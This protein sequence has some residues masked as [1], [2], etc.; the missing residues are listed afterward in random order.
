M[1]P[2]LQCTGYTARPA[3]HGEAC[4]AFRQAQLGTSAAPCST[5]AAWRCANC[6]LRLGAKGVAGS[7][8]ARHY[9]RGGPRG[10]TGQTRDHGPG[11]I[12]SLDWVGGPQHGFDAYTWRHR[13]G[14]VGQYTFKTRWE[15]CVPRVYGEAHARLRTYRA[16]CCVASLLTW[17]QGVGKSPFKKRANLGGT[18]HGARGRWP[19]A[20]PEG[21]WPPQRHE[22]SCVCRGLSREGEGRCNSRRISCK[23]ICAGRSPGCAAAWRRCG[24]TSGGWPPE[25]DYALLGIYHLH[26]SAP[27][28][29]CHIRGLSNMSPQSDRPLLGLG[30]NCDRGERPADTAFDR[31]YSRFCRVGEA[32]NPGPPKGELRSRLAGLR[33]GD[34]GTLV[35]ALA[36]HAQCGTL[37]ARWRLTCSIPEQW[38]CVSHD[39]SDAA[40]EQFRFVAYSR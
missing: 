5:A 25:R 37:D 17:D 2:P 14:S 27:G 1:G 38:R 31:R 9:K 7:C 8:S 16:R 30:S 4:R 21:E 26:S 6:R 3:P 24:T 15:P 23:F 32:Q 39:H 35:R 20:G 29:T 18:T 22:L 28:S 13:Q 10:Q 12:G 11:C 34:S 19:R 36:Q 33:M 40:Q